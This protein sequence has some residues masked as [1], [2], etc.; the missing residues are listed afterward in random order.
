MKPKE[1]PGDRNT[2]PGLPT[3]SR[4]RPNPSGVQPCARERT[5]LLRNKLSTNP[6]HVTIL[7]ALFVPFARLSDLLKPNQTI[8]FMPF[9]KTH[10]KPETEIPPVAAPLPRPEN[11]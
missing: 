1:P 10:S 11:F 3:K 9:P 6:N 7:F 4:N 5:S 8:F 2:V